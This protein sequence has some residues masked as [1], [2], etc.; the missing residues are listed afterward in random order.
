MA[1]LNDI[2]QLRSIDWGMRNYWDIMISGAP[3]P[4]DSWFPAIDLTEELANV[5]SKEFEVGNS[6]FKI[7]VSSKSRSISLTFADNDQCVLSQWFEVWMSNMVDIENQAVSTLETSKML[8]SIIKQDNQGKSIEG[9]SRTYWV[10]PEGNLVDHR[11][12]S[13]GLQTFTIS[14]VIIGDSANPAITESANGNDT[15]I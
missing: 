7:P 15:K 13:G 8:M 4:F 10:Y 14:F 6:S 3:A 11:D 12:G 5:S 9:S 2:E 1:W